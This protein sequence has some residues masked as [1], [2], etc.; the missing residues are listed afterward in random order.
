M[1]YTRQRFDEVLDTLHQERQRADKD[2]KRLAAVAVYLGALLTKVSWYD[3]ATKPRHG[4]RFK[5]G[6]R[7]T[8]RRRCTPRRL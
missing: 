1:Q 6:W 2:L 5:S 3:C 7:R 8:R 4:L